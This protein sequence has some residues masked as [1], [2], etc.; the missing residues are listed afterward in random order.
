MSFHSLTI[1]IPERL[2]QKAACSTKGS[3][4]IP[5]VL[6][7]NAPI[8]KARYNRNVCH[9]WTSNVSV[10]NEMI[11]NRLKTIHD[12][13]RPTYP[14]MKLA[15]SEDPVATRATH[16]A[17]AIHPTKNERPFLYCLGAIRSGLCQFEPIEEE[18]NSQ[19]QSYWPPAT[20]YT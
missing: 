4:R 18:R 7:Q 11:L 8:V 2:H 1:T 15:P 14:V 5:N 17:A 9:R 10:H 19:V 20:G 13:V 3:R 16:P 12:N 6:R